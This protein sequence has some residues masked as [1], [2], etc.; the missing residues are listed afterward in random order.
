MLVLHDVVINHC[1]FIFFILATCN[2]N[3]Y[4]TTD[5][6]SGWSFLNVLYNINSFRDYRFDLISFI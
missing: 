5:V 6:H 4:E 1:C 2:H 3:G